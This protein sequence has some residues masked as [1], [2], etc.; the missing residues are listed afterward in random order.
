MT[1]A[2]RYE[3][4]LRLDDEKAG[5]DFNT[6]HSAKASRRPLEAAADEDA[7]FEPVSGVSSITMSRDTMIYVVIGIALLAIIIALFFS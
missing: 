3:F 4:D 2:I 6:H 5:A 7:P 1:E